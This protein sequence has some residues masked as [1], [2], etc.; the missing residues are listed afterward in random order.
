MELIIERKKLELRNIDKIYFQQ[1]NYLKSDV[2]EYYAKIAKYLLPHISNR[3][4]SMIFF[5]EGKVENSFYQKQ[6][7]A[8][9]PAWID[10][11]KIPSKTRGH[12]DWVVINDLPSLIYFVNRSVLEMHTWFSRTSDLNCPD[13][14]VIDLDP[15][16]NSGIKE[17]VTIANVFRATLEN[18]SLYSM[19]KTSGSRGLHIFIPIEPKYTYAQ[20]QEFLQVICSQALKLY[21]NLCTK[22]RMISKRGDKIYLDAVQCA[23]GKTLAMPYSMRVKSGALVSTP[24][25]WDEVNQELNPKKYD[26]ITIFDR[27]DKMGDLSK[28]LYKH[29]QKLPVFN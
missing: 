9:I 18:L 27:I 17:A 20:V 25:L 21:P 24:L 8:D 5:P 10:T 22:E 16:G 13:I 15:S 1:Q 19:P 3:P 6:K 2:I 28:D 23:R 12:I 11:V 14:A 4:F 29:K 26:I 7:P